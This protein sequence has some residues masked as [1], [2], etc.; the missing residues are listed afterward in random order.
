ME[1]S[2]W[3]TQPAFAHS[4]AFQHIRGIVDPDRPSPIAE[5]VFVCPVLVAV[6]D[7]LQATAILMI[8]VVLVNGRDVCGAVHNSSSL[9]HGMP[10]EVV[11]PKET[12][13]AKVGDLAVKATL[14][15]EI[16]ESAWPPGTPTGL[17]PHLESMYRCFVVELNQISNVE[18][19]PLAHQE[20]TPISVSD[21]SYRCHEIAKEDDI[22]IDVAAYV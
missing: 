8:L 1:T 13:Q 17:G 12:A 6:V 15:D 7:S 10:D 14:E 16:I 5:Q 4:K 9:G 22:C 11:V 20:E 21:R 19:R 2:Q 3:Y 18:I